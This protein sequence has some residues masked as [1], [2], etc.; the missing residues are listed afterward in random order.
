M[1]SVHGLDAEWLASYVCV[2]A[3]AC[4]V[5]VLCQYRVLQYDYSQASTERSI[6]ACLLPADS[7]VHAHIQVSVNLK[8]GVMYDHNGTY[9]Q[10]VGVRIHGHKTVVKL[11][12]N[13]KLQGMRS[14]FS[15]S[16]D[17]VSL[18]LQTCHDGLRSSISQTY[19]NYPLS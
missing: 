19:L 13:D 9:I 3:R 1:A 12:A 8:L 18:T 16:C 11:D 4:I 15:V 7:E 6:H 5:A 10:G 2:H 14:L 17:D